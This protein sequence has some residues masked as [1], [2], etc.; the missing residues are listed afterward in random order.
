MYNDDQHDFDES[1]MFPLAPPER[2][3]RPNKQRWNLP[4]GFTPLNIHAYYS[5]W[6]GAD[7]DWERKAQDAESAQVPFSTAHTCVVQDAFDVPRSLST[8]STA[9]TR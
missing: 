4:E 2:I 6:K 9:R 5:L 1:F 3:M 8:S 7:D